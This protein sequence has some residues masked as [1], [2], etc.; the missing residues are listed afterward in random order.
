MED[1]MRKIAQRT[2]IAVWVCLLWFLWIPLL[3]T[4]GVLT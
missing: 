2:K 3:L 1:A 4:V